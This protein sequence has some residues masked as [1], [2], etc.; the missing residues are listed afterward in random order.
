MNIYLRLEQPK[1]YRAVEN[2]TREAFW[3]TNHPDCDEHLL[4]HKL[5]SSA[6]FVPELDYVAEALSTIKKTLGINGY[7]WGE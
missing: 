2:L 3:G 7:L 4:A 6:A 5:R 1:D